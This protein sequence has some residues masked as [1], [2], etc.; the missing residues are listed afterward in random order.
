M[1]NSTHAHY[2]GL[3]TLRALAILMVI[4]RHAR[5]LLTGDFFGAQLTSIFNQGWIGVELFFVL[6]GFLIGSQL[7]KTIRHER[8]MH[9]GLFY[10]KRSLRILPSYYVVLLLYFIWPDFR[11]K[12][13]IDPAWRFI[14]FIMNYSRQGE[15]FS[16][17]W[18]LCIEEHF[19][20]AF[21]GLAALWLWRPKLFQPEILIGVVLIGS[22]GLRYYLWSQGAPFYPAVYRPSH[23]HLDGLTI[24]VTLA[25]LRETRPELWQRMAARPWL[26]FCGGFL[27]VALGI[28]RF[29]EPVPYVLSFS[30]IAFGF[31]ALVVAAVAP[32]FWL[33]TYRIPGAAFIAS[34]AFTLYLTHK[35][36]LHLAMTLVGDYRK[37][38]ILTLFYGTLLI[39]VAASAMH[40]LIEKPCLK[41]RDR[42]LLRFRDMGINS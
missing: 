24:G 34:L 3:D 6:S 21:P 19:Y 12:P 33:A 32:Q 36:M 18:S 9:F 15:A 42:L 37:H 38:P 27:L 31:G 7:I 14:L 23:T 39:I 28:M 22:I 41:M 8:R 17:A 26:C 10:L 40:F 29:P 4:P 25:L 13:D 5:E 20:L 2:P 16:H 11:E 35:Q 1:K 30:L